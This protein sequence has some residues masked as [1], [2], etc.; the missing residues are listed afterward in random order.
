MKNKEELLLR[1]SELVIDKENLQ[2]SSKSLYFVYDGCTSFKHLIC[3][4]EYIPVILSYIKEE[5]Q[6]IDDEFGI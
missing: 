2:N 6:K 5:I 3:G 4:R 1:R